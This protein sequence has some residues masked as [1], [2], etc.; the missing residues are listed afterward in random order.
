V[1]VD[2][3]T[4]RYHLEAAKTAFSRMCEVDRCE[5]DALPDRNIC[6]NH[7][8]PAA[9]PPETTGRRA[10]VLA[11]KKKLAEEEAKVSEDIADGSE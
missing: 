9:R 3:E 6:E 7:A 5:R 4:G 10:A 1:I 8:F 11:T 2:E